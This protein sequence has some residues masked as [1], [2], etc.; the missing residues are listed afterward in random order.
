MFGFFLRHHYGLAVIVLE[1][2]LLSAP[3]QSHTELADLVAGPSVGA[4]FH[5]D[6]LLLVDGSAPEAGTL[7]GPQ[8]LLGFDGATP[9][10]P[11]SPVTALVKNFI[12]PSDVCS[13]LF[14]RTAGRELWSV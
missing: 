2:L 3:Q 8:G 12:V 7:P 14:P 11:K 6:G 9:S 1:C 13:P 10:L 4:L 5:H